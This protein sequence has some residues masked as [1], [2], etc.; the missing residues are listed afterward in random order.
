MHYHA[1]KSSDEQISLKAY[2]DRMREGQKISTTPLAIALRLP[3][4]PKPGP[5]RARGG[6]R[7]RP[8]MLLKLTKCT[9]YRK[10]LKHRKIHAQ[11][12]RRLPTNWATVV[13]LMRYRTSESGDEQI[14]LKEYVDRMGEGQKDI[15]DITGASIAASCPPPSW[16][17]VGPGAG[18]GRAH[19]ARKTYNMHSIL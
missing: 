14:S 12:L 9:T 16:A 5:G 1:F 11:H 15:Y 3:P 4:T 8:I 7:A 17:Q 19:N 10:Q 18:L 6:S 13:E 2:V